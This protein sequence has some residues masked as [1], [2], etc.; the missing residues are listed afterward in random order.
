MNDKRKILTVVFALLLALIVGL[1]WWLGGSGDDYAGPEVAKV[2]QQPP[3]PASPP[4][5]DTEEAAISPGPAKET[6]PEA[7]DVNEGEADAAKSNEEEYAL[8]AID[9][10]YHPDRRITLH[11]MNSHTNLPARYCQLLC[12]GVCQAAVLG[13]ISPSLNVWPASS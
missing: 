7:D 12:S 1:G 11:F 8:S 2:N 13:C 5:D 10:F 4:V 6:P 9:F 3:V